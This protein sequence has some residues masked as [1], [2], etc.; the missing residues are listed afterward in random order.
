MLGN[1]IKHSGLFILANGFFSD[2]R[3]ILPLL[4]ALASDAIDHQEHRDALALK[5]IRKYD[6]CIHL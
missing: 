2:S 6:V 4:T 3:L 5:A 1:E